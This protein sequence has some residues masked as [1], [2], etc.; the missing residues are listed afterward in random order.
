MKNLRIKK[1]LS[2]FYHNSFALADFKCN[3]DAELFD[4]KKIIGGKRYFYCNDLYYGNALY[5]QSVILKQYSS[6][7]SKINACIEHGVYFGDYVNCDEAIDSGLKGL[8]TFGDKRIEHLHRVAKVPIIPIG[9]YIHYAKPMLSSA[10]IDKIKKKNGKTL[11]VFPT[12][13][14]DRVETEFNM[15]SF[16]E[17]IQRVVKEKWIEHIIVCLFYKDINIGRDKFYINQGYQVVCN[18]YLC[19]PLFLRRLKT[20]IMLSDYTMSNDIGTNVGYCIYLRKPH[21]IFNQPFDFKAY[22]KNDMENIIMSNSRDAEVDEVKKQFSSMK[23]GVSDVQ[24]AVCSKYWG[25][26]YVRDKDELHDIFQKLN[27]C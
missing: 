2:V 22:T 27:S 4:Y 7:Q 12:H 26:P 23:D 9:P 25:Y 16:N 5:G 3:Y 17:E 14:I 15:D 13:S 19:D 10:D 24:Y 21:Y 18:G 6:F 1:R 20:F 11:L 8:I